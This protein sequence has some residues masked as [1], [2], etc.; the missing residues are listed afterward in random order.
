LVSPNKQR[1]KKKIKNANNE[2]FTVKNYLLH[3]FGYYN[4][5]N[6]NQVF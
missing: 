3:M 4:S 5:E 2:L 6:I 1:I